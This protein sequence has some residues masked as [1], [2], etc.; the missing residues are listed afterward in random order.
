MNSCYKRNVHKAV[1]VDTI[2]SDES[3]L[4]KP[5]SPFLFQSPAS[6]SS[7]IMCNLCNTKN[8]ASFRGT[9]IHFMVW[10]KY[11]YSTKA[12][13]FKTNAPKESNLVELMLYQRKWSNLFVINLPR[14]LNQQFY[15]RKLFISGWMLEGCRSR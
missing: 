15:S 2:D 6:H 14:D 1:I 4:I 12:V 13:A 3:S 7:F 10:R 5:F 9:R 8:T 11:V